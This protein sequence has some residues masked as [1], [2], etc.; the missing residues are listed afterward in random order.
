MNLNRCPFCDR[1]KVRGHARLC[2]LRPYLPTAILCLCL[3]GCE[4]LQKYFR[5]QE[6]TYG[7]YYITEE[8][9]RIGAEAKFRPVKGTK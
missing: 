1:P 3:T 4:S 8:G 2:P 9:A 6:R 5:N 7:V